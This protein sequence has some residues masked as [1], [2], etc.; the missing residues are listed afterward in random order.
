MREFEDDFARSAC[1]CDRHDANEVNGEDTQYLPS[2]LL[3]IEGNKLA[4]VTT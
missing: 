1:D 2:E 3:D 4:K